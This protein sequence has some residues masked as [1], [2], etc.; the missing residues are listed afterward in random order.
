MRL[1][2]PRCSA[3]SYIAATIALASCSGGTSPMLGSTT[4]AAITQ[5]SNSQ[6]MTR[7]MG[8]A[9]SESLAVT[10]VTTRVQVG[11]ALPPSATYIAN[12]PKAM[13]FVADSSDGV[14]DI[15]NQHGTNQ[16]RIG[17]I[18]GL[19]F[20]QGLATDG[21]ELFVGNTSGGDIPIYAIPKLTKRRT[22]DDAGNFPGAIALSATGDVFVTNI[23]AGSSPAGVQIFKAG[24]KFASA[25]LTDPSLTRAFFVAVD[26]RNDV[27]VDGF[28]DADGQSIVGEFP[29]NSNH[30]RTLPIYPE[31]AGG[32]AVD[33]KGNLLVLDQ[34]IKTIGIYPPPYKELSAAISI[35]ALVA[36][37]DF[38]LNRNN[39]L[40]FVS[41]NFQGAVIR[42]SYPGG[43][44][45]DYIPLRLGLGGPAPVGVAVTPNQP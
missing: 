24:A 21:K 36:P 45:N 3:L 44:P 28:N 6:M 5:K 22:L 4:A 41:D 27:F 33:S 29:A 15:F 25:D 10:A 42:Y 26:S 2:P 14:V 30:F 31:A 23:I 11:L 39:S 12:T 20:P 40:L 43:V 37:V 38:A 8:D 7:N 35:D 9:R 18:T 16:S 32:I 19:S 1:S 13:L 34:S 17:Q